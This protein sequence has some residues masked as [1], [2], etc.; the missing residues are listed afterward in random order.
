MNFAPPWRGDYE[1]AV[2]RIIVRQRRIS[3]RG[4]PRNGGEPQVKNSEAV[5]HSTAIHKYV[6]R[7]LLFSH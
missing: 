6:G 1:E 3:S 5:E 2:N 7:I 4:G